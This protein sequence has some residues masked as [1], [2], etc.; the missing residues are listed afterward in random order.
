[1][2]T[3]YVSLAEDLEFMEVEQAAIN[4]A[5]AS[6]ANQ[7]FMRMDRHHSTANCSKKVMER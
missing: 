1:L 5:T 4:V 3:G 6:R 7:F 2:V